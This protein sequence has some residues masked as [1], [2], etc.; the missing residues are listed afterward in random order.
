MPTSTMRE[1]VHQRFSGLDKLVSETFSE[2][3]RGQA[4]Q[5]GQISIWPESE[6]YTMSHPDE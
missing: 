4:T 5:P 2:D 1:N 3:S 6:F